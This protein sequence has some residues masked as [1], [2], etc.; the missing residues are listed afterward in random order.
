MQNGL[1][2]LTLFLCVLVCLVVLYRIE[3]ARN[4]RFLDTARSYLDFWILKVE[5]LVSVRF[6]SWGQ[7]VLRQILQYFFHTL[8]RGGI[9]SLNALQERLKTVLRS[10]RTLAKKSDAERTEKNKLEEIA[11]HKM[12]VALSEKEKRIRKQRSL[13][14]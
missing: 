6:R 2:T 5:H 13:E 1:I 4:A 11:L 7:Y 9:R 8:L 14:G 10:N 3:R 12:E